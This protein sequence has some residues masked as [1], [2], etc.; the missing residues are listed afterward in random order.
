MRVRVLNFQ[1]LFFRFSGRIKIKIMT[2]K[3]DA[4]VK[5]GSSVVSPVATSTRVLPPNSL[6]RPIVTRPRVMMGAG[7]TNPTQRVTEAL[8]KPQMG[9]HTDDVHQVNSMHC[10]HDMNARTNVMT[11]ECLTFKRLHS[12]RRRRR[13]RG[14]N[15]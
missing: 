10:R 1:F 3:V 8:S 9:I 14:D 2:S 5:V 7:P 4:S 11:A 6:R 12:R 15:S 13:R